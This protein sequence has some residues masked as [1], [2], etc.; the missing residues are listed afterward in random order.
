MSRF[1]AYHSRSF[2]KKTISWPRPRRARAS[3]RYVV[4]CPLPQEEV[5]ESPQMTIFKFV[6]Q[7]AEWASGSEVAS[8]VC[9]DLRASSTCLARNS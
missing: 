2:S 5:I 6:P 4:A 3:E 7:S 8:C 9:I 1:E